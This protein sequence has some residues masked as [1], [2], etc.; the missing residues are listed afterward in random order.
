MT[1]GIE[2]KITANTSD[3]ESAMKKAQGSIAEFANKTRAATTAAVK[4]SAALTAAGAAISAAMVKKTMTAIDVQ[5]KFASRIGVSVDE[6]VKLQF[7]ADQTGVSTETMNMGLQRMT[8]RLAEAAQGTGEAVGALSE[9]GIEATAIAKLSPD[10]QFKAIADAMEGV[11]NQGDRVRLSMKL[12]DTEG[13]AL[14]NTM[15]GGA[16]ALNAYATEAENLGFVFDSVDAKKIE[17]ANDAFS[18]VG[19]V[20]SGI[21]TRVTI[22][23]APALEAISNL[24]IKAAKDSNGFAKETVSA[25]NFVIKAVGFV[26]DAIRGLQAVWQGIK[27]IGSGIYNFLM[28][29]EAAMR[30]LI[31]GMVNN[32]KSGLNVIIQQ[33]NNL[34]GP[35]GFT[36]DL[37]ETGT[38][39]WAQAARDMAEVTSASVDQQIEKF[40]ELA[41]APM[42]S[43][44]LEQAVE[45]ARANQNII[46]A[47]ARE[48]KEQNMA[49]AHESD[50]AMI[51]RYMNDEYALKAKGLDAINKLMKTK[52][53]GQEMIMVNS[54]GSILQSVGQHNKKAFEASKIFGISEAIVN[55]YVG[56]SKTMAA[57]PYPLNI[58]MSAAHAASA[59]ATVA[60]IKSQSFGGGGGGATAPAASAP[61]SSAPSSGGGGGGATAS[62][63]QMVNLSLTG[64]VFS[65]DTIVSLIGQMN[66]AIADGAQIRIA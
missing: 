51:N 17:A 50:L 54:L 34:A 31:E 9:L 14:V 48:A 37:F 5:A 20:I 66:E 36:F 62:P 30:T 22:E 12:F 42:P 7:A 39:R 15:K 44:V 40:N 58:A 56:I 65:R 10:Q 38:M 3:F 19:K 32:V 23:L 25:M 16:A 28:Q 64:D 57:Y 13:V 45:A 59:F 27:V 4:Y 35:L 60:S 52:Q 63:Q 18:K 6:L 26:A 53:M 61:V 1:T 2:A 43:D 24:F 11:A 46:D 49:E 55:A 21:W 33:M 47:A 29:I 8:R 41:L